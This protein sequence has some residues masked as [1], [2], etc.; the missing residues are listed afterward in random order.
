M[1]NQVPLGILANQ[2][3]HEA[4][5]YLRAADTLIRDASA[6][7]TIPPTYFM[8]SH[9]LELMLK[10]YLLSRDVPYLE[11]FG[12]QHH[13]LKAYE[14]AK[15]LGLVV[16]VEHAEAMTERLSDFHKVHLFRYPVV[17]KEDGSLLLRGTL[18]RPTEV[19]QIIE[20]I[21][22]KISSSVMFARLNAARHGDFPTETWH[23][24]MP[25]GEDADAS[26]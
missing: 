10:A 18:V 17:S 3:W 9:S 7:D 11:V 20:A 12:L 21:G 13:I 1:N 6:M 5:A 23:M 15:S 8:M 24:G 22:T 26:E 16:D 2:F 25:A 4:V 19:L 14:K